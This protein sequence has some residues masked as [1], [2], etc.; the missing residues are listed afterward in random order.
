T[1]ACNELGTPITGGNVSFY[2]ETLGRSIYP[3]PVIGILGIIEDASRVVK[4]GFREA[5]DVILLLDGAAA[6]DASAK[7]TAGLD[8]A[9]EFSSSE[10]AKAIGGIVA[11]EPPAIDLAAEKRLQ[12]FLIAVAGEGLVQSAHDISDGGIAVAVAES[13]FASAGGRP[14]LAALSA[15]ISLEYATGGGP[16]EYELFSERGARAVVSVKPSLVARVLESARQYNVTAGQIGQVTRDKTL[17]IEYKGHA[18]IDSP[19]E[20][21][22]DVWTHSLERA[23]RA[24]AVEAI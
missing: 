24:S 15:K 19:V 11:G 5:G 16:A 3:T 10:Y 9:Q 2:N 1:V 20:E 17:R 12:E 8:P 7:Q 13:C 23:V 4:I 6:A 21:L 22:R 14:E 18:V